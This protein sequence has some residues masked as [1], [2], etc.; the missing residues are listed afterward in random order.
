MMNLPGA[1]DIAAVAPG[2]RDAGVAAHYGDPMREQ[3]RLATEVGL[4][5]RSNRGVLAVPGVER[6]GWLHTLTT[7]HLATLQA[8]QGTELLVLSPNG[9]VEQH[10]MVAEDGATT[11]LDTEPLMADELLAYL[12]KMRFFTQVDPAVVTADWAL[13]SLVGPGAVEAA[14]RLGVTGLAEPDLLAVPGPKFA[15]GSLPGRP[16]TLYAVTPLPADGPYAGG[17]ARRVP[18]GVDLLV[19][20][21]AMA[22]LVTA[23][24]DAG[25]APAG[26]WAYEAIRVESRT[27]GSVWRPITGRFRRKSAC[28]GRR[29]TWTRAATGGR[30]RSPGCTT[31]VGRHAGWCC[32]TWTGSSATPHRTPAPR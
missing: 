5:D 13:L 9:H 6:I 3:R 28:S 10:A 14:G 4:V 25:V 1:V 19:P 24:T 17:W 15:A 26:L 7:Q 30:R 2:S 32:C 27:P 21:A 12:L 18:L 23:S 11:W 31:W 8:G 20:R 16:T 22:Q 29:S